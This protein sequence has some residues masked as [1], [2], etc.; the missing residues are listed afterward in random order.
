MVQKAKQMLEKAKRMLVRSGVDGQYRDDDRWLPLITGFI[1]AYPDMDTFPQALKENLVSDQYI[2]DL[3]WVDMDTETLFWLCVEL[4][5]RFGCLPDAIYF[6]E[7]DPRGE[8]KYGTWFLV[9][10]ND[11][12][13]RLHGFCWRQPNGDH[14]EPIVRWA[15]KN[16]MLEVFPDVW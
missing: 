8:S 5:R 3:G 2:K 10:A 1:M 7:W 14:P 6:P 11:E 9:C 16:D 4:V 12:E 15:K 13:T